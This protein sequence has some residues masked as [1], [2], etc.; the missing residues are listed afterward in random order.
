MKMSLIHELGVLSKDE[1]WTL[2]KKIAFA[3]G[4]AKETQELVAIEGC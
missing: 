2:F 3:D 4:G 1:S